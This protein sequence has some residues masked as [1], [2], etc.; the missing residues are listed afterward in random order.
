MHARKRQQILGLKGAKHQILRLF[1]ERNLHRLNRLLLNFIRF[2]ELADDFFL[3]GSN[4]VSQLYSQ[5]LECAS[6]EKYEV[7]QHI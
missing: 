4:F 1:F 2:F 6:C 7:D 3:Q 5:L